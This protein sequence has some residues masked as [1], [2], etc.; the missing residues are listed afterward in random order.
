[1]DKDKC[2]EAAS[3]DAGGRIA[4]DF[5]LESLMQN[6]PAA[7]KSANKPGASARLSRYGV[8]SVRGDDGRAFLHAQLTNDVTHLTAD[9]ARLAG[10]CS[11]K[12]RL[13]ADLL[14]L[15]HDGGFLL[16]L[17]RD[18]AAPIAKRL[19]MFVL[20]SKVKVADASDQLHVI[21]LWGGECRTKLAA[22]G[23]QAPAEDSA[24]T[25][26]AGL[27]AVR[28][29]AEQYLLIAPAAERARIDAQLDVRPSAEEA[30]SL[31][32]IRAGRPLV[33]LATQEAFVPQMINLQAIGGVDFKK[34]CYPGQEIVARA[35]YRG[36]VKRRMVR[37]RA[38]RGIELRAG[39]DLYSDDNAD[40]PSGTV[41]NVA[42][43]EAGTELLAVVQIASI[44]TGATLRVAPGGAALEVLPLPY[45]V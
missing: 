23:L 30:W 38:P 7:S 11:A 34:G 10:W 20:R 29:G 4:A 36:Q 19:S 5:T 33:T 6:V 1:M 18:L 8:L 35:Q 13:L 2:E 40:Q 41:V 22:L 37:V 16:V 14:L 15:E 26:A 27:C 39:Q 9:R 25:H 44:E 28:L 12:G 32:E 21:G 24:V 42:P 17:A 31:L 45:A 43:G 3:G